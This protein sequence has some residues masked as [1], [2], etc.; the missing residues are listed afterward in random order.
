MKATKSIFLLAIVLF[1]TINLQGQE[2]FF[3]LRNNDVSRVKTLIE[4]DPSL[5]NVKDSWNRTPLHYAVI[6]GHIELVQL[7]ID[8]GADLSTRTLEGDTPLNLAL[9]LSR[10]K[11]LIDILLEHNADYDGSG[12]KAL[13]MLQA[14]ARNG[15]DR[16]FNYLV[17]KEGGSI[18]AD[19]EKNKWTL[20]DVVTGGSI[21]LLE[22]LIDR[23]IPLEKGRDIY[24]WTLIHYAAAK[25]NLEILKY[26]VKQGIDINQRTHAGESAY[27]LAKKNNQ[28]K[29][30]DVIIEL[31]GK[32]DAVQFPVHKDKY[33][34][35]KP[36]GLTPE[37]F[38]PGIVS[39]PDFI[40][41]SMTVS[42]DGD[43]LFFYGWSDS[44]DLAIYHSRFV[45]D[46]WTYPEVFTITAHRPAGTP[47]LAHD[48]MK[49][50]FKWQDPKRHEIWVTERTD[51]GWS[52]PQFSGIGFY[53][54]QT[55]NG[56]FYIT[57]LPNNDN[58]N[59]YH[60]VKVKIDNNRMTDYERIIFPDQ[61]GHRAHPCIAPDGSFIIFDG[62]GGDRMRIA[63]RK[64]DGTWG[65]ALDLTQYG[66]EPLA[67]MPTISPDGKYLFF[68]QGCRGPL[69]IAH[70]NTNRDIWWVDAKI[71][72][73]LKK[74]S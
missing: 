1:V 66:F 30:Q 47:F 29:M 74:G 2:I 3:A 31:G 22:I 65:K 56:D 28:K 24:G 6:T 70:S 23:D 34:G 14:S 52:N 4:K 54:S 18:F 60:I 5:V 38:A 43:E 59:R 17:E 8:K 9:V 35:E 69:D 44:K 32:K 27:N 41:L 19:K 57:E 37:I 64:E 68:K 21:E 36:P 20:Q 46:L 67:G 72:E 71:I 48:N 42:S 12:S 7:F 55:R 25:G 50:F 58:Q 51:D 16:M 33:L 39:R 62:G 15:L 26:L 13:T 11:E 63:F 73:E 10:D 49:L 45:N 53:L 40:E 61:T